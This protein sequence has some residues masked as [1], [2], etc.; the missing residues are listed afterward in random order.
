MKTKTKENEEKEGRKSRK[1]EEE[2]GRMTM[3]NGRGRK[4]DG[5]QK[6]KDEK[7]RRKWAKMLGEEK[8]RQKN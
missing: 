7:V 6:V 2:M 5:K 1:E 8:Q 4:W 3:D